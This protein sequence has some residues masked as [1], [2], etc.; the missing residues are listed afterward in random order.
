MVPVEDAEH[1]YSNR[2]RSALA[3]AAATADCSARCSHLE[4]ARQYAKL[5]GE[6]PNASIT[7]LGPPAEL[8]LEQL[9]LSISTVFE[10]PSKANL[11]CSIMRAPSKSRAGCP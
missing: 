9:V 6:E 11:G 4:M 7:I 1:Y 3:M 2:H 5:A 8:E 10:P